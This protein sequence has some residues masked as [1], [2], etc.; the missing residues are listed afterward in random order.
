MGKT[1][2]DN[3]T[4]DMIQ[5]LKNEVE[6]KNISELDKL[7]TALKNNNFKESEIEKIFYKNVIRV[8]EETLK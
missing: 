3:R 5:L 8:F 6:I 2:T 1:I 7:Y 4:Y